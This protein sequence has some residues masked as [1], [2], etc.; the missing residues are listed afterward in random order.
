MNVLDGVQFSLLLVHIS[1]VETRYK[2]IL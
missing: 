1:A 2:C